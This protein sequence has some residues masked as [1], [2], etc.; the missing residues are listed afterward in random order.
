ML[1][2]IFAWDFGLSE[3]ASI[4]TRRLEAMLQRRTEVPSN[5]DEP[6]TFSNSNIPAQFA[7]VL[8]LVESVGRVHKSLAPGLASL[9]FGK[10]PHEEGYSHQR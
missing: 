8:V 3:A 2:G 9:T 6:A 5:I 10:L 7:A 1:D 4:T